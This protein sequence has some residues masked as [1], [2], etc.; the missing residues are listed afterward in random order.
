[1]GQRRSTT[2]RGLKKAAKAQFWEC[3][4]TGTRFYITL[5][6]MDSVSILLPRPYFL[7]LTP[8]LAQLK[9]REGAG[10]VVGKA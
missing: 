4:P 5:V 7:V 1:M 8:A 3:S 9:T 10:M 2:L 6:G